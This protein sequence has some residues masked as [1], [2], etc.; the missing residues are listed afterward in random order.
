MPNPI[1]SEFNN[2]SYSKK[3][4]SWNQDLVVGCEIPIFFN[5]QQTQHV[6]C[7]E[8]D[9]WV[10]SDYKFVHYVQIKNI[11]CQE[12]GKEISSWISLFGFIKIT[13][14]HQ[15]L[16]IAMDTSDTLLYNCTAVLSSVR[17][18]DFHLF[19]SYWT[20]MI[21]SPVTYEWIQF[22]YHSLKYY[23]SEFC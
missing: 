17:E 13:V 1:R 18:T 11:Q 15:L 5:M 12:T 6:L 4:F 21:T 3:Y 22:L 23:W 2:V 19:H 8:S 14:V 7:N 10:Y 16:L 20:E 9:Q